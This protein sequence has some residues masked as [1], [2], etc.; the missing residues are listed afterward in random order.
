MRKQLKRKIPQN[1]NG[2]TVKMWLSSDL[3]LSRREITR[4]K[5]TGG[6][7]VNEEPARLTQVLQAGDE[8]RILFAEQDTRRAELIEEKPEILYED[9]DLIIVNKPYGMPSH[10]GKEHTDDHM[11]ILL[12]KYLG[13]DFV[14][15]TVG[16]LD[17][18]VSGIMIYAKNAETT[19]ALSKDK[20]G[21]SFQKIYTAIAEGIFAEKKGTLTYSLSKDPRHRQADITDTGKPCIT[22]YEVIAEKEDRSVLRVSIRTGRTHQIRA[23][24][25]HAGHPLCG[26]ALYG[27][28]KNRIRRP[29]L[30]CSSVTFTHPKTKERITITCDLPD[31][32]KSLL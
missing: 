8:V 12:Q 28:R 26:D 2:M 29:A 5:V 18:D 15:R 20:D 6:I 32:M 1:E 19:G 17:K 30:H 16:R 9:R 7:L 24:M 22:D 23:G 27:G 13:K 11:G 4:L 14:I 10:A 25:A 3:S 31:D 21:K